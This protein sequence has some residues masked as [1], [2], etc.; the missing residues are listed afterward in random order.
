MLSIG[1][2]TV[3]QSRYYERQVAQGR[4]DYYSGR[5]ESPGRWIGG[6]AGILGLGGEVDDDGFMA[7]MEGRDPGTG[8]RLKRVGGRSKVAAFDLT[9]SAPKS[10]SVL[11]AIGQPGLAGSL[12]EAHE[13]AVDAALGYLERE[14]CRV[15][16]GRDGVRREAGEGFVTAAYRHRMSRAE[17]PQLHTHVVAANMARGQDGRWTAL[18]GTPIYQHAKAAGYLYQAHLRAAVRERVPWVRWGAVR[19]GMA[20]IEQVAAGVLR[21]FSARR[22]Q[23]EERERELVTAGVEVGDGGRE[24][25]AHAT[26]G[27][28]RYGID[29]A[30]W[31]E[32]VR[33][34]AAEHGLGARELDALVRGPARAPELPDAR[35]VSRELAGAA[36]L[37]EKQNTFARREAVMAWAAAHGQGAP[38]RVVERDAAEFLARNDVHRAPDPT[39]RRF[40]TSDLLAHERAI[41]IGAQARRGEGAGRLDGALVDAVLASAPFAPTAGQAH[42]IRGL[43]SSGHGVETVEA[44]AGTGKTFTAGLLAQAYTAGGFRVLGTAPTGR[45]VRELTEQAGIAQAWTLTR[46]ALDLDDS[47]FGNWPAVLIL[48]EAGMAS[49][50]ETARV[51]RHAGGAGVKVIAIGDSG[52]L[53]SVQAGGWLGSLTKRLGSHE[54]REV[55]RQ[56]DARERQLLAYVHR[57]DPTDYIT[58]KH[59]RGQLR[60]FVGDIETAR[61]GERAAIAAWRNRQAAC[62]WGQAVLIAR[63]NDRRDHLNALVRAELRR[64]GRLGESIHVAGVEFAVGDRVVAR[65]N[66]RLLAVDNG[67]RGTVIAV[68]QV[69]KDVVV[70]TDAGAHRQ[71]DASYVAEHLQH[72]Y[73]L[74][75]HTVQGGTVDWAGVVGRA[76]DFTRNWSYTALSRAREATELFLIDTPTDHELARAEIAPDQ[77]LELDDQRTP[78]ERLEA[79]MRR[80]DDE[81]L[82]LDRIDDI[83]AQP[84]T[85]RHVADANAAAAIGL[86]RRSVDELR[87]EL[88]QLHER[89]GRYPDHLVDQLHAARYAQA[90]AQRV[91]DVAR[92]RIAQLEQ[93]PGGVLRRRTADPAALALERQRLQ[94]AEH[95]AAAAAEHERD[96][97]GRVPDR[98]AWEA[99]RQ[100]LRERA[101]A[102]EA[103]LSIRRQE[104]L[105]DALEHPGPYLSAML[106]PLPHQPRARSTWQQAATHIEAYRFDHAI[107]DA[108]DALG[109]PPADTRERAHWQHAR[110]DLRRAQRDLGQRI[111]RG[112]SHEL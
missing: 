94:L 95:H 105:R 49:T 77:A 88:D 100:P 36:G 74:T 99:E 75:A 58:E 59:D 20:E 67:T 56:R 24:A 37:T 53:S 14:A 83:G 32:V 78:V 39:E 104:H 98:A 55:M 51:L 107:T 23:I 66:D 26:R 8:E 30:P 33:A 76:D 16:R 84:P 22:R 80:R 42:V 38:A 11:F 4:D 50:R 72:A 65:Q 34:R 102:L 5:G 44:L 73:A 71:L 106:G 48:D 70:R 82:A 15:R 28:K 103:Q 79:A 69:E 86:S 89:I 45:A 57:G 96:F 111:D 68:D 85:G 35:R 81:S 2:L 108:R 62:P 7:L 27:R 31:R 52:Q 92:E 91:A 63:D 110:R 9:F 109:P 64:D 87:A 46:L 101:A 29:T 13:S 112:P 40:T 3:E 10:V 90:E 6:G 43:T 97:A 54:L 25:I 60:I 12:V 1:K 17:D 61:I 93:P 21:E 19:N 41:V 47:G 18:D